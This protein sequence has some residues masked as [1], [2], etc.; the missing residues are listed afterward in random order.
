MADDLGS[1][2]GGALDIDQNLSES[3]G[4]RAVLE[5]VA[6]RWYDLAGSLFYDQNYGVGLDAYLNA[7]VKTDDLATLLEEEALK[8]ERVEECTVVVSTVAESLRI[9]GRIVTADG[10]YELTVLTSALDVQVLLQD[11]A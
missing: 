11:A 8:D 1:D 2:F 5:C 4:P 3:K 10:Q 9:D 6:R 7:A